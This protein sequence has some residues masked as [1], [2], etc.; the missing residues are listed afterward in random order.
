[1]KRSWKSMILLFICMIVISACGT[2]EQS[3]P[4]AVP[5]NHDGGGTAVQNENQQP[6]SDPEPKPEQPQKPAEPVDLTIVTP[7]STFSEEY[8]E[9]LNAHFPHIHITW[10]NQAQQGSGIPELLT[11]NTP[12]DIIGRAAGGYAGDVINHNLQYDMSDLIRQYDIDLD[13]FEPQL[14]KFIR[15]MSD[16]GLIGIPGG[17][18]INHVIF[19][20]KSVFDDF[21]VDYPTDGMIWSEFMDL[22]AKMTRNV[23]GKQIYG[24]SGHTG[25]MLNWNQLGLSLADDETH[26]PTINQDERWRTIFE[27]V[28]GNVTLNAAYR[29]EGRKFTG[30]LTRMIDGDTAMFLFNSNVA[31]V[32]EALQTEQIDWDMIAL[33]TFPEAPTSGSP[34]NSTIWGLTSITRDR[35]AAME[36]LTYLVSD[37][38]L[39]QFSKQ[40]YLVAKLSDSIQSTFATE[41]VPADKNWGAIIYND[42]GPIAG[43]RPPYS[44]QVLNVYTNYLEQIVSGEVDRNTAFRLMEEEAQLI[45]DEYLKNM[46]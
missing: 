6:K 38:N 13:A 44:T 45:I 4:N 21:G 15:D 5:A 43:S 17:S 31:I 20:N 11:T 41:A 8:V 36:V 39:S 46:E 30:S 9:Q 26:K 37:E 1:M 7:D 34:M 35:D 14:L 29:S 40:G 16:G 25:V 3:S 12:I 27:T 19:Y 2:E 23:D 10:L 18:A 42:F 24:F 28:F 32:N 22:A 33:P